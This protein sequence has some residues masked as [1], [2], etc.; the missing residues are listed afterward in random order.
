MGKKGILGNL[1]RRGTAETD[2]EMQETVSENAKVDNKPES[3]N[4]PDEI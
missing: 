3:K 1:F 4:Q 2:A